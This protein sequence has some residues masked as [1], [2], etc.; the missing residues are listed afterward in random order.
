MN[1]SIFSRPEV[2][3]YLNA[4]FINVQVQMDRTKHDNDH[5]KQWYAAADSINRQ[6]AV[7]AFPT[8]LFISPDGVLINRGTGAY[9]DPD[10]FIAKAAKALDPD[11]QYFFLLEQYNRGQ[12]DEIFLQHLIQAAENAKDAAMLQELER[13]SRH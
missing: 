1:D 2:I 9:T 4:H 5:I 7:D 6:Y 3:A 10:A 8:F 12:R 11:E 13:Y